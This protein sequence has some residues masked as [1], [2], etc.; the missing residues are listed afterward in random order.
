M[1][2][3]WVFLLVS[4]VIMLAMYMVGFMAPDPKDRP[5]WRKDK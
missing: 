1:S 3:L 4:A 2:I 5:Q